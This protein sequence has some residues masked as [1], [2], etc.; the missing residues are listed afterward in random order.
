VCEFF[1]Y[2]VFCSFSEEHEK[3]IS[4]ADYVRLQDEGKID[5]AANDF[6]QGV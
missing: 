3:N 2:S 5:K 6:G 1:L 4:E